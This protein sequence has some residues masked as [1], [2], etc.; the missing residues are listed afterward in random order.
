MS[1]S[2]ATPPPG[3]IRPFDI[4][5]VETARLTNGMAVYVTRQATQ[6]IVTMDV[7]VDAAAVREP[8]GNPGLAHLTVHAVEN[9]AAG[10][11]GGE[12]AWAF[13]R[14]GVELSIVAG[15]D[16]SH[17]IA[18]AP[19]ERMAATTALLRDVVCE[20]DFP[21][22]EVTRLRGEQAAE[23][24]QRGNEPRS[25]ASDFV[26]RLLY[27]E[28][29]AYGRHPVG[30]RAGVESLDRNAA[31]AHHAANF[32]PGTTALVCAGD[33]DAEAVVRLAEDQFGPWRGP[34]TRDGLSM[35]NGESA[36][37]G[38][39]IYDRPGSVQSEI[40]V[41]HVAVDRLHPDYFTLRVLETL[42][43]GAFTSRLNLNLREKHGFTYGVRSSFAFRRCPGPF[44]IQTA[45][46]TEVTARAVEEILAETDKLQADGA[47]DDEVRNAAD[48]LAGV[49][50]LELEGSRQLAL[51]VTDL[52]TY[53]LPKDY[54]AGYRERI[55]GVTA[56]DVARAAREQIHRDRFV[57]ALVGDASAIRGP[58]E[59]LNEGQVT[60]HSIQE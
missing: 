53:G 24:L 5:R 15:W 27:G 51:R 21:A 45:V 1:G 8:A 25:L 12:L 59:A 30:L 3:P 22:D 2:P 55:A 58:L 60:V 11:S 40:R 50:P 18:T 19:A 48:Y 43:G 10:R 36:A 44:V 31:I 35:D 56:G 6:P 46:A 16:D 4:P 47:T 29:V 42:F 52:F 54:L 37:P 28:A 17:L 38:F 14:Q 20:P 33:V 57:I 32:T 9:G 7:V 39:H 13:E 23:I 34:A 41:G 49:L 26:A